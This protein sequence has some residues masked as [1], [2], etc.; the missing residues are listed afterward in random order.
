MTAQSK[1]T[2]WL[3]RLTDW[4]DQCEQLVASLETRSDI[5]T[6]AKV[7][8]EEWQDRFR[9]LGQMANDYRE[10][11]LGDDEVVDATD[12]IQSLNT[13]AHQL[14]SEFT[15][16]MEGKPD[17]SLE[18][19]S[20]DSTSEQV[21]DDERKS[22]QHQ[23]VP[24]GKHTLPPL[25]YAYNALEPYISEEIM[26]LHH[27]EH[28]QSYVDGLNKA[29]KE[30]KKARK[31][32]DYEL[33]SHWEGEAAFNG[34]GHY[35]HTIF[36]DNMSPDGGGKPDGAI[37]KEINRTFGSFDK[38][39]EHFTN[40]ADKVQAVGWA[41]LVW[42]PRSRRTEI[43]QVEKHQNRSQQ[44]IIPLLVLD[45]WE[46]AYYLQYHNNRSDYIDAWWN[47][48]CW[49]SVNRRFEEAKKVMWKPY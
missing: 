8:P 4:T 41:M 26:R 33:I 43:L 25:P 36:W 45:V 35:L 21:S 39:K 24:I 14:K 16:L 28:H 2:E 15:Q 7:D 17:I 27:Q 18:E 5:S 40:A 29:E 38:F 32:G 19:P 49:D 46:H 13:K 12:K 47:V 11:L 23:T 31:T 20:K 3:R 42:S 37:A 30:M 6:D 1:E 34:A 44:D 48:V 22:I 10:Q 9:E